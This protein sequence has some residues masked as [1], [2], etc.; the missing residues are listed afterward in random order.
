MTVFVTS[1]THFYHSALIDKFESSPHY[2]KYGSVEEFNSRMIQSWNSQVN[3]LD[4]VYHLGDFAFCGVEKQKE[5]ISKLNGKIIFVKGNH[6][7][8]TVF[9]D[10]P[11]ILK[12]KHKDAKIVLSHFPMEI[13][14]GKEKG[15]YHLHGHLHGQGGDTFSEGLRRFDVGMCAESLR[16]GRMFYLHKLDDVVNDLSSVTDFKRIF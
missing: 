2:G 8:T 4:T 6:D 16:T 11:S 12:I 13:W 5:I 14:E 7:E 3:T 10:A 1:D 9:K 15:Y